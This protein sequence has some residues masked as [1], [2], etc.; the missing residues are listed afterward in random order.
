MCTLNLGAWKYFSTKCA[1]AYQSTFPTVHPW[2]VGES[3]PLSEPVNN[4]TSYGAI[5]NFLRVG[6]S[7]ELRRIMLIVAHSSL[8]LA[9]CR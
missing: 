1:R 3:A 5:R 6:T 8:R 9:V 7:Q 2:W 4:S